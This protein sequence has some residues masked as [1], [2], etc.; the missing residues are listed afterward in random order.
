MTLNN[1]GWLIIWMFIGGAFFSIYP[2]KRKEIVL[3][4]KEERWRMASAIFLVFPYF[5]WAGMRSDIWGDTYYYR[6][7]FLSAPLKISEWASYME[8]ISKDKGFSYIMLAIKS[9]AGNSD[10]LFF[11]ILAAI[12]LGCLVY[13]YRKYSCNYWL[14]MYVFI[15]S[16][17]YMSWM[18][19]G[20]RQFTAV[21]IAF[22]A[23]TLML[24]KKYIPMIILI[25][26]ASTI[27][28][29]A[30]LM[31]PIVFIIQGE[32]W[33][34][35]TLLFIIASI[36]ALVFV[37]QFTNGL[38]ALLSDT[39]YTNIVSD[40]KSWDD[41]GTNPIRVLVYSIPTILSLVGLKWIKHENSP[42]INMAVNASIVST[43]L[44]LVSMGTSGIFIGRLPIYVSLYATGILLPWEIDN[45]FTN[46]S[47]RIIKI[48]LIALYGAF[49]YY[50]M[51]FG[52][53]LL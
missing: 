8:N 42:I 18:H 32:A 10:T 31:L 25:L 44:Y 2:L 52:W 27:H 48:I 22:F 49:F 19:N 26:I 29:S 14:S 4:K 28:G 45:I 15:A 17:D 40:W 7:I 1:F 3:G 47:A 12:Q 50:Q 13:V 38:D 24:K 5:I 51:H 6:K 34:K 36:V 9:I 37:D 46:D 53:A 33:N 20:I 30:L 35:K 41:D 21:T 16:T 39:Q 43:A 23:S 11:L